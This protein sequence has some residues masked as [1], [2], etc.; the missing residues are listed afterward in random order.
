[1]CR[2]T[3]A[4]GTPTESLPNRIT[5]PARRGLASSCAHKRGVER[6]SRNVRGSSDRHIRSRRKAAKVL[7]VQPAEVLLELIGFH[8]VGPLRLLFALRFPGHLTTR[9]SLFFDH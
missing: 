4:P 9:G 5:R 1:M 2:T 3:L 7:G 8:T 6:K